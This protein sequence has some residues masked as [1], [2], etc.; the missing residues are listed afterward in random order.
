MTNQNNN[1]KE[2]NE[3][4]YS[5][6]G[7]LPIIQ[8]LDEVFEGDLKA[9]ETTKFQTNENENKEYYY[10]R[11]LNKKAKPIFTIPI[12]SIRN[13]PHN[14][15]E[16]TTQCCTGFQDKDKNKENSAN[17]TESIIIMSQ[18][19]SIKTKSKPNFNIPISS[20]RNEEQKDDDEDTKCITDSIY[21]EE[22]SRNN[23]TNEKKQV[24]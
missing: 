5:C 10:Q 21:E 9:S 19:K 11:K 7:E 4:Y 20:I 3:K 15:N 16:G 24:I 8:L 14:N 23:I 12:N 17:K 18:G 1:I 6:D 13:E 2:I 22:D